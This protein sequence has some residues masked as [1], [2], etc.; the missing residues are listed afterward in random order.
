[1]ANE[2]HMIKV[3]VFLHDKI[4]IVFKLLLPEHLALQKKERKKN[5]I[6]FYRLVMAGSMMQL[7]ESS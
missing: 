2:Y 1:M 3:I 6:H 7:T 5:H 4:A